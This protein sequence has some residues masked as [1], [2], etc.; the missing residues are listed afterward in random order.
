MCSSNNHLI[1]SFL[2]NRYMDDNM[3]PVRICLS[4]RIR[5][6]QY[7][8]ST[9]S[10]ARQAT[11]VGHWRW[12]RSTPGWSRWPR[13]ET[14]RWSRSWQSASQGCRDGDAFTAGTW[15]SFFFYAIVSVNLLI[16]STYSFAETMNDKERSRTGQWPSKKVTK[17]EYCQNL[18]ALLYRGTQPIWCERDR[19][20]TT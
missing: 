9:R 13:T 4:H 11:E 16:L 12:P 19:E 3:P 14:R 2:G 8:G 10:Q 1:V 7:A 15:R 5:H 18:I 17:S 20:L 6:R